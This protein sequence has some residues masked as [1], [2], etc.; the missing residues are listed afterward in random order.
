[1]AT[2]NDGH[3]RITECAN[4]SA[5]TAY[6]LG[7]ATAPSGH[8]TAPVCWLKRL[9]T[10]TLRAQCGDAAFFLSRHRTLNRIHCERPW[11]LRAAGALAVFVGL[12][13]VLLVLGHYMYFIGCTFLI[14]G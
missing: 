11:S 8:L 1:M 9:L 5:G 10:A 14:V 7:G 4:V 3:Y 6:L 12:W 13:W 2:S